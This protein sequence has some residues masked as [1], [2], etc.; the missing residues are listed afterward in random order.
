MHL[1]GPPSS[2]TLLSAS[3]KDVCQTD[4]ANEKCSGNQSGQR[5]RS[6]K[7]EV[8]A[9][10]LKQGQHAVPCSWEGAHT[11]ESP[12]ICSRHR[13]QRPPPT[14]SSSLLSGESADH[15]Q[16]HPSPPLLGSVTLG[17]SLPPVVS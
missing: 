16:C 9:T 5:D 7:Q 10:P 6:T 12:H 11:T 1:P 3:R 17:R 13:L 4:Q 14:S 2:S 15:R 8:E